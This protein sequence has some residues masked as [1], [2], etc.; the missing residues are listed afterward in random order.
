MAVV[1]GAAWDAE[2][3][4][5]A[6]ADETGVEWPGAGRA[7]GRAAGQMEGCLA[8]GVGLESWSGGQELASLAAG[9]PLAVE[10]A[11]L[12]GGD[13]AEGCDSGDA[14]ETAQG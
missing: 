7:A 14:V 2:V 8:G 1:P 9:G 4:G 12:G 13:E 3:T 11:P 6:W 10:L 5:A